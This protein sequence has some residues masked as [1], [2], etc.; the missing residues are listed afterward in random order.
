MFLG[1]L[2]NSVSELPGIGR[3][4]TASLADMGVRSISDLLRHIP[5]NYE[6]RKTTV[7]FSAIHAEGTVNTVVTVIEHQ[8]FFWKGK[9]TLKVLLTDETG[10]AILVCYGRSFLANTLNPGGHFYLYGRFSRR[11]GEL[12]SSTFAVEPVSNR[13]KEFGA[14][15]PLYPL[16]GRLTHGI[17]RRAVRAALRQ[18][19]PQLEPEVP[20]TLLAT[21]DLLDLTDAIEH[22]HFPGSLEEAEMSR[23]SLA[24]T[25]LLYLQ[26]ILKRR[27]KRV[28][29]NRTDRR[30]F[31]VTILER[32]YKRLPFDLTPDQLS[33][34][35]TIRREL[36]A[37]RTMMRLLQG[38]VGC[39]KTLVAL[40]SAALVTTA[41]FQTAIMAPTE[42]LARQ[43]AETAA[44]ILEPVGIRV[45]FLS[46]SVAE[47]G[48]ALLLE[49]LR[50]GNLDLIVG[51]HALFSGDVEYHKL[52]L[53]IIDEQQ[54]FGVLQRVAIVEKGEAP[55]LLL[56]T[57]TPIPRSLALTVFG[58]LDT[59]VIRTMPAGRRPIR[60]HLAKRG[61]EA[62]VY[63]RVRRELE[64][65]HQAYF[66]YPLIGQSEA[67]PLKDAEGMYENLSKQVFPNFAVELIHSRLPEEEKRFRMRRFNRGETD[68]LVAT[69][70]VEV[71]VDVPNATCM[72]IEQAER[73]GLSALHQLRG[74][75]GRAD[76]QSYAFL[77]YDP[78]ITEIAKRRLMIM[79]NSNDGFEIAEEDLKI[80][81]PGELTGTR[82]AGDLN[83]RFADIIEDFDLLTASR[84]DVSA[85]LKDDPGLLEAKHASIREVLRRCPPHTLQAAG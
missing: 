50:K 48:R 25:E 8:Y 3:A 67:L 54:R 40:L 53:V 69:S 22:I 49:E 83:L 41:G 52:G 42:L 44:R 2:I 82:Q 24:Y 20:A 61:N 55:D 21:N 68:V 5:R 38:D 51:T 18:Y 78:E 64:T 26:L 17:L 27:A 85:I 43:Q 66:V 76:Y 58:D 10:P 13:P 74:R 77:I 46:G 39:G 70:V 1:E 35:E 59:S 75:V 7:N 80:R 56:M 30:A 19:L 9:R 71:G 33:A 31:D 28:R 34:V 84:D 32:I 81:G 63:E 65:G 29:K 15:L 16:T 12:Q 72:V 79:K 14:F 23:R 57:A 47:A 36:A 4:A 11:F 62:K 37:P 6:D 60:T 45:G 73:F